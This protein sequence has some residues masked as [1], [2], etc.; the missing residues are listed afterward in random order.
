MMKFVLIYLPVFI[1][2]DLV[3]ILLL[4][5]KVRSN[6]ITLKFKVILHIVSILIGFTIFLVVSRFIGLV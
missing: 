1:V 4:K 5:S 6:R 3:S 2:S